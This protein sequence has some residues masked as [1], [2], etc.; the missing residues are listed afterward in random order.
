MAY[1]TAL[2]YVQRVQVVDAAGNE[3]GLNVDASGNFATV[4]G[5][6]GTGAGTVQPPVHGDFSTAVAVTA[7]AGA[8]LKW[9]V[10]D[11]FISTAAA[12]EVDIREETSGTVLFGPILMPANGYAQFTP[13]GK[14]KLSTAVLK[15]MGKSSTADHCTIQVSGYTEA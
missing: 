1:P 9:V 13:R 3:R 12:A 5:G 14:L 15:V 2:P 6:P 11:I 4:D 7:A 8:G 10:T